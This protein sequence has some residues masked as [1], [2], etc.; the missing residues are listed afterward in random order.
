MK[1]LKFACAMFVLAMAPATAEDSYYRYV[2]PGVVAPAGGGT[3]TVPVVPEPVKPVPVADPPM[4]GTV[5]LKLDLSPAGDINVT[6][7]TAVNA[8]FHITGGCAGTH[9]FFLSGATAATLAGYGLS[10]GPSGND[11]VISGKINRISVGGTYGL[12]LM[13]RDTCGA[14]QSVSTLLNFN[15]PPADYDPPWDLHLDDSVAYAG[16]LFAFYPEIRNNSSS[17]AVDTTGFTYSL[18]TLDPV[19]RPVP[20]WLHM[21]DPRT[22]VVSGTAPAQTGSYGPYYVTVQAP[23]GG[24]SQ[25]V[26]FVVMVNNGYTFTGL[27]GTGVSQVTLAGN[28]QRTLTFTG[29]GGCGINRYFSLDSST[30]LPTGMSFSFEDDKWIISGAPTVGG[31]WPI[32]LAFTDYACGASQFFPVTLTVTGVPEAVLAFTDVPYVTDVAVNGP[33]DEQYIAGYL[34]T[35]GPPWNTS[36]CEILN[37]DGSVANIPWA[38]RYVG[39]KD[40][41]AFYLNPTDAALAGTYTWKLR[42]TTDIRGSAVSA[43]VTFTVTPAAP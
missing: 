2:K 43:P 30:N 39:R 9:G 21:Q 25:S 16:K 4:D 35:D 29:S 13:V 41:C 28:E 31:T 24:P 15:P 10:V 5:P 38:T 11:Y 23:N 42:A 20:D 8:V 22:G 36:T 33:S 12:T 14:T 6:Y 32:R 26:D 7:Q 19:N 17:D 3:A 27:D 18:S 34:G 37:Q 40:I 1:I